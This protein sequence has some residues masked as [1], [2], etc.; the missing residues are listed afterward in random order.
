MATKFALV[1]ETYLRQMKEASKLGDEVNTKA[2]NNI[3]SPQKSAISN[4]TVQQEPTKAT[5]DSFFAEEYM[6][7]LPKR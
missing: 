2:S 3:S 1:S 6:Q 4:V 7:M 5:N